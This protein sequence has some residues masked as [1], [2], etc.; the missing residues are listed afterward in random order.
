MKKLFLFLSVITFGLALT[1]CLKGDGQQFNEVSIVYIDSKESII[2][3][4]TLTGR[5]I[6][7]DKIRLMEPRTFQVL[8]YSWH[9]D[10]G[11]TPL[12][13]TGSNI[14]NVVVSDQ[15]DEI[16]KT[17]LTPTQVTPDERGSKLTNLELYYAYEY[18]TYIDD[19]WLLAYYF[20]AKEGQKPELSFYIRDSYKER[21]ETVEIDVRL[22]LIGEATGTSDKDYS[23]LIAVD[24]KYIRNVI[25]SESKEER[26][27]IKFYFFDSD[28]E[29]PTSTKDFYLSKP[30]DKK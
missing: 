24:M 17:Y 1:S 5:P 4:K 18:G 22:N 13:S 30:A 25:M 10:N 26:Q 12:G 29:T 20:K 14:Y 7:S 3:G 28:S 11:Y 21:P 27:K 19:Y 6:T 23:N 16:K 9:E 15:G 8:A 2:Y